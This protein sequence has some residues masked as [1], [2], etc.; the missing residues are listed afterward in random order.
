M[1]FLAFV[2]ANSLMMRFHA[3]ELDPISL[4][5]NKG[6]QKLANAKLQASDKQM[7]AIII[8]ARLH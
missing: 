1:L 8:F 2:G 7:L 5:G 6:F 4:E 3:I